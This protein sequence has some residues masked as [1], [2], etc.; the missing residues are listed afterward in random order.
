MWQ[1]GALGK[2]CFCK[3]VREVNQRNEE[4]ESFRLGAASKPKQSSAE[5]WTEQI[6]IGYTP[7]RFRKDT[8]ADSTFTPERKTGVHKDPFESPGGTLDIMGQFTASTSKKCRK[9]ILNIYVARGPTGSNLLRRDTAAEMGLVKSRVATYGGTGR[10]SES[11]S[12]NRHSQ[13]HPR[14][15]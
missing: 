3:T 12:A 4:E 10:G 7:V 6:H 9:H 5:H 14:T 1:D 15:T 11:E 13:D 8:G 2:K